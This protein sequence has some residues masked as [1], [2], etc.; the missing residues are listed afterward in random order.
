MFRMTARM[1]AM[2]TDDL[3]IAFDQ[4]CLLAL[5]V[6]LLEQLHFVLAMAHREQLRQALASD[7]TLDADDETALSTADALWEAAAPRVIPQLTYGPWFET[8][9]ADHYARWYVAMYGPA[10]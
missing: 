4:W 10:A 9:P 8:L 1:T 6:P 3:E 5:N 2:M 7:L